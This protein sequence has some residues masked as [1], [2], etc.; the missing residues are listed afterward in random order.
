MFTLLRKKVYPIGIDLGSSR[1]KMIQLCQ[2]DAEL[3]LLAAAYRDV[4]PELR[5]DVAGKQDWY[6]KTIKELL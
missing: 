5:Q 1:L 3:G 4:P 6:A 2:D